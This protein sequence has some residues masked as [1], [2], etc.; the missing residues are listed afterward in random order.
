MSKNININSREWCDF[1]FKN[2]NK[3]YG[4]YKMRKS[5]SR[6]HSIAFGLTIV[7]MAI[8]SLFSLID[9]NIINNPPDGGCP[10]I[11]DVD[12]VEIMLPAPP[13]MKP[14]KW[15]FIPPTV[16]PD[17]KII[18]VTGDDKNGILYENGNYQYIPPVIDIKSETEPI[19]CAEIPIESIIECNFDDVHAD[20]HP[21][22]DIL[23]Q[24]PG[25]N[26]ELY[27]FLE[28]NLRY[29]S[30]ALEMGIQGRVIV[31]FTVSK[32]GDIINPQIYRS[33]FSSCD[34]EAIRLIEKMPRWLPG[35]SRGR[36]V[37]VSYILPIKF[38]LI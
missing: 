2:R 33:L 37:N 21:G 24:F 38:S 27:K 15:I 14:E 3:T 12:I 5:S 35:K 32:T 31:G 19:L 4:A 7:F 11:Y 25:G 29:P 8:I 23:P 18:K 36:P 10:P 17:N 6:D 20:P 34:K 28:K 13:K 9:S 26:N 16:T 1:V 30:L 22:G